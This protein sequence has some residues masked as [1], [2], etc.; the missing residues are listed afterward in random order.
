MEQIWGAAFACAMLYTRNM[1]S[2]RNKTT[3]NNPLRN[4]STPKFNFNSDRE[5]EEEKENKLS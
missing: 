4:D 1:E 3:E 2:W 5:K